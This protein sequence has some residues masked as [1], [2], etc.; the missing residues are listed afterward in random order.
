MAQTLIDQFLETAEKFAAKP[1]LKFKQDGVWFTLNFGEVNEKV[2]QFACGLK[3]LGCRPNDKVAI[4][5]P[6]CPQWVIAD[7]ASMAIGAVTVPVHT[8]LS[9][10]L[11]AHILKDS[12]SKFLVISTNEQLEEV[13]LHIN[14]LSHLE[15]IIYFNIVQIGELKVPVKIISFDELISSG[16]KNIS[17]CDFKPAQEDIASIIYTSGT[18]GLPKGVM[19]SHKNFLSNAKAALAHV[20]VF[21]D[22]LLLSFLPLS[23]V[24]ERTA[25]Y[26]AP[27][28]C[29][30]ACIAYAQSAKTLVDDLKEVRPTI[31]ISVPRIFER[32]H[33]KI[34]EKAMAGSKLKKK[35]FLTALKQK[36]GTF[37]YKFF[38]ILVF[39][40]I[41]AAFGGKFRLTI[42][43]G[44]SLNAQL[45]KFFDKVG[46]L[47]IEG[48][49]LTETSPVISTN[50]PNKIKFGSVGKTVPGVKVKI[51]ADKEI[52]VQGPNVM[53]GYFKNDAAA[54][55]AIDEAGWFH[56]GDLG[57]VDGDGYLTIIG[58]K[59]E[60]IVLA[61]GKNVWPEPI[62]NMLN[63]DRYFLQT[64]IFGNSRNFI[65]CLI[66]PNWEEVCAYA[67]INSIASHLPQDLINDEKIVKLFKERLDMICCHLS[68][69]EKPKRFVL[70]ERELTQENDELTPT[71]K[72]RR[73]T[74]ENN[75]QKHIAQIYQ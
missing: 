52:L 71:L 33:K 51:V 67:K 34:W 10:K 68:D 46:I 42:S 69:W 38:D 58:R 31:L 11:T 43:G 39:K 66:V 37:L 1:A 28:V 15:T 61:N 18:T 16:Q 62:E 60:M 2:R 53:K 9:P 5:S 19:L 8:T 30:G 59:K 57:F 35:L 44:A 13:M 73:K 21:Q 6:N 14:E 4:L 29:C 26:Y 48:Y 36:K 45:A 25:G 65:I 40:K 22:D 63:D 54:K 70:L 12:E 27:F 49:G 56:T 75:F 7:L 72:L 64:V 17:G 74:I 3:G 32:V 50:L 55:E 23:H 41:R 20:P 47:I 24:L